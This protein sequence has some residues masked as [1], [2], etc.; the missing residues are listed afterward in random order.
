MDDVG[1]AL[2]QGDESGAPCSEGVEEGNPVFRHGF[3]TVPF[4]RAEIQDAS[5]ADPAHASSARAECVD[6]PGEPS[7]RIC[8]KQR[9]A[10]RAGRVPAGAVSSGPGVIR[11]AP[12]ADAR[13]RFAQFFHAVQRTV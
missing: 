8:A 12:T 6:E 9:E 7:E 5:V 1:V 10:A 11:C 2:A 4:G 3:L 13:E